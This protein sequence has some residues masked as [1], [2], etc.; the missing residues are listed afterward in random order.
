MR[1]LTRLRDGERMTDLC[2]EFGISRKTGYKFAARFEQLSV[3]GLYDQRRIPERIPHR[4]S[5]EVVKLLVELRTAHPTWGPKKLREMLRRKH[6]DVRLPATSTIGDVLKREG[7]ITAR[8]RR[9]SNPVAF[10]PLC[11]ATASNDVWCIDFKGHFRLGDGKYCYP[12]T[13]TDA[14]SRYI[15]ACEAYHRINGDDVRAALEQV[16]RTYGLPGAMRF[17]GG[18][19]FATTG[20]RGLS[21]L[22]AWWLQLGIKLERIEPASPQQNGRHER[23]HRTLKAETTRPPA[24]NLLQQQE[25]FD[26]FVDAFNGERPHEALEMKHPAE[27]YAPS[28]KP[29]PTELGPAAYP[30]HDFVLTVTSCGHARIPG[31]PRQRPSFFLAKALAR[32][33]VGVREIDQDRWMV[34]F[35][36]LNLGVLDSTTNEFTPIDPTTEIPKST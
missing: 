9:R 11:H 27:C 34:T 5:D 21:A 15:L 13:V 18:P 24:R 23:M 2:R 36:D 14:A 29:F 22:S 32:H 16:F 7:L 35:L 30:F 10:S 4:T 8:D 19:P 25:R 20:L 33:Q 6:A 26:L 3:L 28:T 17:D 12:L 31:T 1:F